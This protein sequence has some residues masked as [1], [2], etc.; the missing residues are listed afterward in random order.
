MASLEEKNTLQNNLKTLKKKFVKGK[1]II[2]FGNNDITAWTIRILMEDNIAVDCIFDNGFEGKNEDNIPVMHPENHHVSDK[3]VVLIGSKYFYEMRK[4][5]LALGYQKKQIIQTI[6][7][8]DMDVPIMT[9]GIFWEELQELS[10]ARAVYKRLRQKAGKEGVLVVSIARSIGDIYLIVMY[11]RAYA[12]KYSISDVHYVVTGGAAEAICKA[13]GA[14]NYSRITME[15][16]FL[17]R[18]LA[19]FEDM[20]DSRILFFSE[21][22]TYTNPAVNAVGYGKYNSF[23]VCYQKSILAEKDD[24]LRLECPL[25]AYEGD[26]HKIFKENSLTEGKTVLLAPYSNYLDQIPDEVWVRIVQRLQADGFTVCTNCAADS[27]RAVQGS[28]PI[29]L[30][31]NEIRAFIETAGYFIGARSGLCDV[32][33][34]CR[35]KIFIVYPKCMQSR[36]ISADLYFSLRQMKLTDSGDM[37]EYIW[38]PEEPA[39]AVSDK[40]LADI[41]YKG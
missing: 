33:S 34:S 12:L 31:F 2:C 24:D 8:I 39:E 7:Y 16:M 1:E 18:K 23:T 4:Q 26:I 29:K 30:G 13:C 36:F 40:I 5:L 25:S 11:A 6:R 19:R 27:E 41:L 10:K 21:I 22:W 38:D 32:I 15:E 35:A 37:K 20:P 14:D 3:A 17:L 28:L 9:P